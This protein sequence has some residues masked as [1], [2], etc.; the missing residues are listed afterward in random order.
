MLL[1]SCLHPADVL[2]S[3]NTVQQTDLRKQTDAWA[4]TG[5]VWLRGNYGERIM[6]FALRVTDCRLRIAGV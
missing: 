5:T 3:A 6:G 2:P 4:V 1:R